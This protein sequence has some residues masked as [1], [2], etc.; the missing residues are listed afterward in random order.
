MAGHG[1][2]SA[3][4]RS[5]P[6]PA[7]PMNISDTPLLKLKRRLSASGT[8]L[9]A[10]PPKRKPGPKTKPVPQAVQDAFEPRLN[11]LQGRSTAD[12]YVS[13]TAKL[14]FELDCDTHVQLLTTRA[15]WN[16]AVNKPA[17][18]RMSCRICEEQRNKGVP[19]SGPELSVRRVA[20]AQLGRAGLR[21]GVVAEV[22]LLAEQ[23]NQRFAAADVLIF[24]QM[25]DGELRYLP[26]QVDGSQHFE[27]GHTFSGQS[28]AEQQ[29][30]DEAF[31]AAA[32]AQGYPVLRLHHKDNEEYHSMIAA[33]IQLLLSDRRPFLYFSRSYGKKINH[34][35]GSLEWH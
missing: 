31:N 25:S 3:P 28:L 2:A 13:N 4:E 32:L 18:F 6:A 29:R 1:T 7:G 23:H 33:A 16:Q 5:G 34:S 20:E 19:A 17:S 11:A 9:Q 35:D 12:L 22:R 8:P 21:G 10:P 27:E 14:F 26:V 30:R 24:A 15:I